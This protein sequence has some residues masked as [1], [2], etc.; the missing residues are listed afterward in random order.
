MCKGSQNLDLRLI[1]TQ[2][3][4]FSQKWSRLKIIEVLFTN[5]KYRYFD[6]LL[7]GTRFI[8]LPIE[9]KFNKVGNVNVQFFCS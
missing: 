3:F 8:F 5:R 4:S 2:V 1:L 6:I 7:I 9:V